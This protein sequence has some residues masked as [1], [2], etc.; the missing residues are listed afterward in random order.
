MTDVNGEQPMRTGLVYGALVIVCVMSGCASF[1]PVQ[2]VGQPSEVTVEE[3][4]KSVGRGLHDMRL[5]IG[6]NKTGLVPAEVIVN[7]KL[8]ASAKDS[9]K[10]TVD[11]SVPLTSGGAAGS[12]KIGAEAEKSSEGSRS[13]EIT[14]K[15]VNLLL[16][17][18]DTLGTIKSAKDI[19]DLITMLK[20]HGI[21]PMFV[22]PSAPK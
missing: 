19:D 10:L 13:N 22:A 9:G 8:A 2:V 6:E 14:I 4:L 16:L 7:F 1:T 20:G 17:P 21:T 18:K 5:E 12:G 3:A 15:F 11:L